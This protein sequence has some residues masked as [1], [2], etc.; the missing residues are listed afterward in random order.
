MTLLIV[1]YLFYLK[2]S[3]PSAHCFLL[4]P[5]ATLARLTVLARA[6]ALLL[7][8]CIAVLCEMAVRCFLVWLPELC[9]VLGTRTR[10]AVAL[11][12]S[13]LREW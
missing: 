2:V 11:L 9:L 10:V 5:L 1:D 12:V 3:V 4:F 8:S 6:L 7:L 13:L